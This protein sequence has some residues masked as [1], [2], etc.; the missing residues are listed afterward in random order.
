[1]SA[2]RRWPPWWEWELELTPHLLKRMVDRRFTELEL[3]AMLEGAEGYRTD[4]VEGRFVI[5]ARHRRKRWEVIVEPD[6]VVKRLVVVT[7]YP[8]GR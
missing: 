5:D 2:R 1:V 3:R 4:V 6:P 8:L 7:A